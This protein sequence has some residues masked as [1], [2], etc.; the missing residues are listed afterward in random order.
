MATPNSTPN[1]IS[2]QSPSSLLRKYYSKI[3]EIL[4][5]YEVTLESLTIDMYSCRLIDC[6]TKNQVLREKGYAGA[7]VLMD[8]IM[9]KLDQTPTKVRDVFR[10]LCRQKTLHSIAKTMQCSLNGSF[11]AMIC[12]ELE[13]K[14]M[15]TLSSK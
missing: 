1:P 14:D 13:D 5:V 11:P 7:N 15:D 10:I 4:N 9:L 12:S 3:C 2:F 6:M 8:C